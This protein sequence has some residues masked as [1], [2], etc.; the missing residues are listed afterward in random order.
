[1]P[2]FPTILVQV[3]AAGLIAAGA[4]AQ[5]RG[6]FDLPAVIAAAAPG[7]EVRV[8]ADVYAGPVTIDKPLQLVGEPGATIDGGGLGDVL[9]ITADD[10]TVRGLLLRNT[11]ISLDKENAGI[12]CTGARVH[13]TECVFEDV[14]FGIYLKEAP[15]S[16]ISGNHIS[17]KDLAVQRR[18]D[19]IRLWQSPGAIVEDNEVIRC[20]DVVMWFSDAVQL[21]RNR[22][23][24]G[25]YGLHFMYSDGNV[26]EDNHLEHN[27][28]GAFLMYSHNLTL[29]RNVFAHNRGPSGYGIGLK[30]MDGLVAE[31]NLFVGNRIG[32]HLDNSPSE[33]DI[34]HHY[35]HNVFAYNDVGI[36]FM[37][38]VT[39]NEFTENTMLD[40]IEQVAVLGQGMFEGNRF[41]VDGVG[42]YWSDYRGF[43]LDGDGVGDIEYKA[44]GLFENLMDREP[45]LRMFLFSPAE[46]AV[47][48]AARAFPLVTPRPKLIDTAPLMTPVPTAVT[49]AARTSA[50][51]MWLTALGLT[52]L[53]AACVVGGIRPWRM[54]GDQAA[55]VGGAA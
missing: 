31:D 10:V 40:N 19:G 46:H 7:A 42:N 18:G 21:R 28:V 45:K 17:S 32:L 36:A 55:S 20:R 35:R 53:G 11:G 9:R 54:P 15:D 16:V 33:E 44:E 1:M 51:P 24:L 50:G 39:R 37:P 12:T 13:I 25:R 23:T 29:R 49:V 38:S 4:L 48:M 26:L 6:G 5:P 30:D 3:L 52:T 8:P 43:D 22:I 14:L 41:T 27:S 47:E 2:R 34:V